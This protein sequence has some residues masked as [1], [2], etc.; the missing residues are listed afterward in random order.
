MI[1]I[2]LLIVAAC[3]D[4]GSPADQYE[5]ECDNDVWLEASGYQQQPPVP[6]IAP[7]PQ[8]SIPEMTEQVDA[9]DERVKQLIKQLQTK[10]PPSKEGT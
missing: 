3:A 5:Y 2:T 7:E 1:L 6:F 8:P 10:K 4:T 9:I